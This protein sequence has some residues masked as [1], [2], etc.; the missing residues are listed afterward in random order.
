MVELISSSKRIARKVHSCGFC[1]LPI[2]KG[3][4]YC[5]DTLKCDYVYTW[6]YHEICSDIAD[7]LGMFDTD[8]D[9]VTEEYFR[10]Y[11][12][13]E[14]A[15]FMSRNYNELWESEYYRIPDFEFQLVFLINQRITHHE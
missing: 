3:S 8:E 5:N 11:I 1:G 6:K 10:E 14:Y 2:K 15:S 9:G 13:E 4:E 12:Q 7:V